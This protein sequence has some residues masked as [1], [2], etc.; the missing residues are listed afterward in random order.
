MKQYRLKQTISAAQWTG[1]NLDELKQLEHESA[2]FT[3]GGDGRL[4]ICYTNCPS[5][6]IGIT[7]FV[8]RDSWGLM[9]YTAEEFAHKY[10]E[11][12]E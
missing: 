11:V 8:C 10:V 3:V 9:V 7:D 4:Y 6:I 1:D 5:A 12:I 2:P